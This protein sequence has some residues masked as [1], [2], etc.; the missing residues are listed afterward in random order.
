MQRSG[1]ATWPA[2]QGTFKHGGLDH[3]G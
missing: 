2:A 1:R 3:H